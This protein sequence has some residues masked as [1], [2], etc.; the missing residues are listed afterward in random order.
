M[1]TA[2]S[3]TTVSSS[4]GEYNII[5]V[6]GGA[7]DATFELFQVSSRTWHQL[8]DLPQPLSHPSAT[9]YIWQSITRDRVL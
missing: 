8:K 4:D 9:I 1:N 7:G 2:S 6:I 5:I 3:Q